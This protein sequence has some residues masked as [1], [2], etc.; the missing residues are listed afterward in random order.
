M[1]TKETYYVV[2]IGNPKH[3]SPYFMLGPDNKT[4]ALF[5]ILQE[6]RYRVPRG[7]SSVAVKV[8]IMEI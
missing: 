8:K 1:K 3:H 7:Q 5:T 6:A 4:P 2:R